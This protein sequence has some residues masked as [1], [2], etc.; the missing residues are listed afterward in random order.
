MASPL[1]TT[2]AVLR[3]SARSVVRRSGREEQARVVVGRMREARSAF[4]PA[5]RRMLRDEH[6]M[7][8]VLATALRSDASAI[9]VGANQGDTLEMILAVAPAGRHIAYEP[10]PGLAEQLA[11]RYPQVDVRNAACSDEA[12]T[13]EFAHVLDAPAMSGLRQREDL[14]AHAA[15]VERIAVRLEKLDDALPE[16]FAPALVKIDVEGAELLVLRGAV[17]TLARHRPFV[18]FEHGIGG[19]DLYGSKPG[20]VWDLLHEAGLRVFDLE[21]DGPYTR[22]GFEAVFAEPIWNFLA[23]PA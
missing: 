9:D 19:A 5:S 7:R 16:G 4:D 12:G 13:A 20:E 14:P 3:R 22:D 15:H 11:A 6:A 17:E 10:I 21:G 18:I 8:V 1:R 2:A 23:A